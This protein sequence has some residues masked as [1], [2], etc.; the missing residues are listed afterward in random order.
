MITQQA[1]MDAPAPTLS[2]EHSPTLHIPQ[3]AIRTPQSAVPTPTGRLIGWALGAAPLIALG[4]VAPG[5]SVLAGLYLLALLVVVIVDV[6]RSPAPYRY[7]LARDHES[8]LSLGADNPI[9]VHVYNPQPG[10]P[11]VRVAVR[12]TPPSDFRSPSAPLNGRIVPRREITLP[13]TVYPPHRGDYAFGDLY[14]RVWSGWGLTTRQGRI[15]AAGPVRVYPNLL[16]VRRYEMLARRGALLEIGL[17]NTRRLGSGTEF[18]RLREY[19]SSDSYRQIAWAAT[20]RRG[21]PIVVEYETEKSQPVILLLDVGRLMQAPVGDLAKLDYAINTCLLLAFVA[22]VKGDRVGLLIF[23]DSVLDWHPPRRG[24]AQFLHLLEALYAVQAQ[25]VESSPA[26]ATEYLARHHPRRALTILFT[27]VLDQAGGAALGPSVGRLAPRH[28]PL[29][30]AIGDPAVTAAAQAVPA[31]VPD[32]YTRTVAGLVLADRRAALE[33]LAAR[34][35]LTLD[36]PAGELSVA[37]INRY[38]ELKARGQL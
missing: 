31:A 22:T 28:L 38:L 29:V 35:V 17:K 15:P 21:K 26:V 20:A 25:P 34:G 9:S 2:P 3:S 23:A 14:L 7:Q 24:R 16:D 19:N 6:A 4:T 37:V 18:E 12:D 10:G 1:P 27:D 5:F 32:L 11:A 33:P 30:V 13:Y 36:V 8:K